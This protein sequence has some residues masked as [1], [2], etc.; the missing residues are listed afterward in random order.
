MDGRRLSSLRQAGTRIAAIVEPA[1]RSRNA[2]SLIGISPQRMLPIPLAPSL[3]ESALTGKTPPS[4]EMLA[5]SSPARIPSCSA[6]FRTMVAR[7]R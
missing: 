2:V 3:E 7:S 5:A 1:A 4:P 6:T